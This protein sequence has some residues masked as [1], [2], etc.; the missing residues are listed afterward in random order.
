MT[1]VQGKKKAEETP[2]EILENEWGIEITGSSDDTE[3]E[4]AETKA[5]LGFAYTT[6]ATTAAAD[7]DIDADGGADDADAGLS[8]ADLMSQ[9]SSLQS[10]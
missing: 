8:V 7:D 3:I 9:L 1:D 2:A 6:A 4:T 5:G 10:E